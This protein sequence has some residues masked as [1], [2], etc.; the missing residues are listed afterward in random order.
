MR[1]L[2]ASIV[3]LCLSFVALVAPPPAMAQDPVIVTA[4][5]NALNVFLD[6][7]MCDF[8]YMRTEIKSVNWVR[9]RQVADVHILVSTQ[10][11]GAGGVEYTLAFLGLKRVA[12]VGDTLTY[13]AKPASVADET[14]QG[15]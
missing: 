5:S 8:D 6:C 3:A 15:L 14:R 4:S 1:H 10:T 13:I 9:D 2:A 7:G 11:T 12:G